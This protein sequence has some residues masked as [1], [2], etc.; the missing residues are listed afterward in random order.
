MTLLNGILA[1]V[2]IVAELGRRNEAK[3]PGRVAA[4]VLN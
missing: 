2:V 3:A 1:G 4:V